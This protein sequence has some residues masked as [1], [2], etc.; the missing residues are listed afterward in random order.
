MAHASTARIE[1]NTFNFPVTYNISLQ[2]CE[3]KNLLEKQRNCLDIRFYMA[4]M[5][6]PGKQPPAEHCPSPG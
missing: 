6:L 4:Q 1:G 2:L 3:P 5:D